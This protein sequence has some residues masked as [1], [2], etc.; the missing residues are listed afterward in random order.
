MTAEGSGEALLL[1]STATAHGYFVAERVELPVEDPL[2]FLALRLASEEKPKALAR[3]L[4]RDRGTAPVEVGA[5]GEGSFEDDCADATVA[6]GSRKV[7]VGLCWPR[8]S[9]ALAAASV[10]TGEVGEGGC[11]DI[12]SFK[13]D[14]APAVLSERASESCKELLLFGTRAGRGADSEGD[15]VRGDVV[16]DGDAT[17]TAS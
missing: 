11:T 1:L 17:A 10:G 5:S 12:L 16:V 8:G 14:R 6:A 3:L 7:E 9:D 15:E 2:E 13:E 4:F